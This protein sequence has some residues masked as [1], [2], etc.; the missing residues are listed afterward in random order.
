MILPPASS[1]LQQH[2]IPHRIFHHQGPISSLEQAAVE[3]NQVPDQVVRSILFRLPDG[4]FVLVLVAGPRQIPWKT[5]RKKLGS[6]RITMATEEEVLHQTGATP[7]AVSP[8][9]IRENVRLLV[10]Q[11]ILCQESVSLGSGVRGIAI[12]I[13]TADLIQALSVLEPENLLITE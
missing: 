13:R 2:N 3:R 5:L 6:S 9:G 8:F 11:N 10:D 1:W 4:A 12:I 7:G